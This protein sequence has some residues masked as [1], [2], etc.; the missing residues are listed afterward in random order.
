MTLSYW[1]GR[2][3]DADVAARR[4]LRLSRAYPYSRR[5]FAACLLRPVSSVAI[6]NERCVFAREGIPA[7]RG[8]FVGAYRVLTSAPG[9]SR[10]DD[11][12][13]AAL[14]ILRRSQPNLSLAWIARECRSRDAEREHYLGPSA[15]RAWSGL[16]HF[17]VARM[18]CQHR[19]CE[20]C[21]LPCRV[22]ISDSAT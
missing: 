5:S 2:W 22:G 15:A 3:E 21:P 16:L 12:A 8:A 20:M 10:I 9:R 14:Q 4:A 7:K 19:L 17:T 18:C 6:T 1:A 13:K 11:V